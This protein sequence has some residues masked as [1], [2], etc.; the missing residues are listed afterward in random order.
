MGEKVV[1][2]LKHLIQIIADENQCPTCDHKGIKVDVE[3]LK[4]GA[5]TVMSCYQCT[6]KKEK[7]FFPE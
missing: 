3:L 2:D 5:R 6:W 1:I 4:D 7:V